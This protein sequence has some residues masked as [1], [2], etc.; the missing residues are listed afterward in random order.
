[1]TRNTPFPIPV[2]LMLL[3]LI[4]T[5]LLALGIIETV[6]P[7]QA[8]PTAWVFSGLNLAFIVTGVLLM[9]PLVLHLITKAR[10]PGAQRQTRTV[11]RR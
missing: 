8:W 6:A 5:L 4:G 10:Q 2:N 11:E 3:D 7:G 1:M 9:L